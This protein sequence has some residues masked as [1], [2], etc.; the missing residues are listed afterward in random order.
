MLLNSRRRLSKTIHNES[1]IRILK[2]STSVDKPAASIW[3]YV[4]LSHET[5]QILKVN[6]EKILGDFLKLTNR[7]SYRKD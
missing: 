1:L 2:Y 4:S 3:V 5:Q 6:N 7:F